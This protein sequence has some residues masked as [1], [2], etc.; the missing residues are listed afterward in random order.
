MATRGRPFEQGNKMGRGRPK[1]SRNKLTQQIREIFL[2]HAPAL[3]RKAIWG[4]LQG[5][6]RLLAIFANRLLGPQTLPRKFGKL[7]MRTT[8]DLM[9][10]SDWV[11]PATASLL[12]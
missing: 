6:T 7:S 12:P 4:G 10:M 1:G 5:D 11:A 2:T 9:R 8:D 3:M